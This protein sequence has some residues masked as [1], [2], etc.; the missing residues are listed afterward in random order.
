MRVSGRRHFEARTA[1]RTR[2]G[3][4]RSKR[5]SAIVRL[6]RRWNSSRT[7]SRRPA[8][9]DWGNV[10]EWVRRVYQVKGDFLKGGNYRVSAS[11]FNAGFVTGVETEHAGRWTGI[12]WIQ[13]L[14]R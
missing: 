3:R 8:S 4:N 14:D 12:R 6:R 11:Y 13:R 1:A 5:G 9:K 7:T 10:S 2:E